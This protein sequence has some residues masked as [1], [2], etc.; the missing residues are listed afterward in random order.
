M[1]RSSTL[2][3]RAQRCAISCG[4]IFLALIISSTSLSQGLPGVGRVELQP[5]AAQVRTLLEA[6]DY[7]GAPLAPAD[8]QRL[9][10]T[11]TS[12]EAAPAVIEMQSVLDKYCL[13]DIE[14]NPESRVKVAPGPAA[15]MLVEQGWRT[16]LVKVRNQAGVTAQ[17]RAESSNALPVYTRS[18]GS[19][20]PKPSVSQTDVM[21]R[22]LEISVFNKSPLNARLSGLELEYRIIQLYSRDSGKRAATIGFNVGQGTQDIGFRND[23]NILFN[24]LPSTDITLRVHDVDGKPTTASFIVRDAQ[25]HVYP[26]QAKRLAPD[27]GFHPQVYRSDGEKLRL[28]AGDY[29]IEFTRGPEYVVKRQSIKVA[30]GGKG[31][32]QTFTFRLERWFDAARLGWYSG[33]HH[34]H[35][36]GCLHYESPTEGVLPQ[37]MIRHI[38]GEALNI[39]SVLTWGPCYYHQKQFFE[40]HV[41]QL[42]TP[43]NLMRYDVEVS[44]F[45]SSHNGHLVLLGLKDQNYPGAKVLEEWPTWNLPI[46]KWAKSQGAVV[47]FAHSGWG[48]AVKTDRLPNYEMP[49]FDGIGAN[50]YIVDVVHDAVDFI[51]TIDTPYVWELNVWYHTLNSGFR[52]RISG[53]TDFP[54]IYG[55]RVGLGRSYVRLDGKLDFGGWVE[56]LRDVRSYVSDGKGHLMDFRVNGQMAGTNGSEIKLDRAG[57]VPITAKVAARLDEQPNEAIRSRR[58]D[59]KPYWDLERARIG[60]TREVAVEVIVNGQSVATKKILADGSLRDVT[61]DVPIARSSWIAIRIL[62][63]AHTNPIFVTVGGKPIRASRRSAEWLLKAVDQCWS[64]KAPRISAREREAAAVAYDQAR[65]V[66]RRILEES[67]VD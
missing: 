2:R 37:D 34:V 22:W 1:R 14:I 62:H 46:L 24:C 21:N 27:F 35:A 9:E 47:G 54:C 63:S 13:M 64:Q 28:P 52:A 39:G 61:F 3:S 42:S 8:R 29:V 18:T 30:A 10:K 5:L 58:Y 4:A 57:T 16:F 59:E 53:E 31:E 7:L 60:A 55:D 11:L 50:E 66:Y 25:G 33:D 32:P 12:T 45:P 67:D 51:S 19:P 17:L 65:R 41:H 36:A 43:D 6:L 44:G 38:L 49:S 40:G 56:G 26:S 15:A 23:L 48:L 20:S